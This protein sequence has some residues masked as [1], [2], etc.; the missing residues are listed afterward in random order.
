M[1]KPILFDTISRSK[2]EGLTDEQ[3]AKKNFLIKNEDGSRSKWIGNIENG[4]G[5]TPT[6]SGSNFVVTYTENAG[7]YTADKTFEEMKSAF[8]AGKNV[9]AIM[10]GVGFVFLINGYTC[11]IFNFYTVRY[12]SN[13]IMLFQ[14]YHGEHD[15]ISADTYSITPDA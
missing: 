13:K 6:P 7:T 10:S 5:D 1:G 11:A 9:I 4:G 14:I 8:E 15:N 12:L 2:F 3:K